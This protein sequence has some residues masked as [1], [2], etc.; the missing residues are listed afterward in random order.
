M[1]HKEEGILCLKCNPIH[2]SKAENLERWLNHPLS[3]QSHNCIRINS[4]SKEWLCPLW[5]CWDIHTFVTFIRVRESRWVFFN[6]GRSLLTW[7]G[8]NVFQQS[9]KWMS[10]TFNMYPLLGL[11]FTPLTLSG[12][13][14]LWFSP[15]SMLNLLLGSC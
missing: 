14:Q 11:Q 3:V 15:R 9:P 5:K 4:R 1:A 8:A 7:M 12:D 10:L 13:I 6:P 2:K